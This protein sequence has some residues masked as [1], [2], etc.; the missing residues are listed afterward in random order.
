MLKKLIAKAWANAKEK[1]EGSVGVEAIFT[2]AIALVMFMAVMTMTL[3]AF[4]D[5]NNK[6]NMKQCAREY[7]LIAET[8]GCLT[9]ADVAS[10]ISEMESYGLYN[11]TVT[12]TTTSEV[13]YGN[14]IYVCVQGD[15]DDTRLIMTN[16]ASKITSSTEHIEMTRM[17]TAK[18]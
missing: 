6:W 17:T 7:L 10:M 14:K 15:Y 12:G 2:F 13:P 4:K 5:I 11:V 18:Q 9:T 8:Q 16:A 3:A 1:E